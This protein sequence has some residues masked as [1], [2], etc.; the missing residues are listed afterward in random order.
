MSLQ[1][2]DHW[3]KAAYL[4]HSTVFLF[5]T[6]HLQAIVPKT[7]WGSNKNRETVEKFMHRLLDMAPHDMIRIGVLLDKIKMKHV[8]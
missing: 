8:E 5:I 4:S 3:E 1:V 2:E 7:V 6:K